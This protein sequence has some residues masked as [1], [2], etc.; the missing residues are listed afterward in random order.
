MIV[1]TLITQKFY[2]DQFYSNSYIAQ[3]GGIEVIELNW[4]E[5]IFI[6]IIDWD[7]NVYPDDYKLF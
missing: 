4:L 7:L 3:I 5:Q 1:A 2:S 6:K